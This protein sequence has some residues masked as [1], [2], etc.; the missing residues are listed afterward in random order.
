MDS[1][2]I[3]AK[4]R[5]KIEKTIAVLSDNL[6]TVRAGRANPALLNKVTVDYY[7]TPTP[8]KNIAN[9]STPDPRTLQIS[10]FDPKSIKDIEKAINEADLGISPSND[11]KAIRLSIQPLTEERRK[12]LTKV[13]K[14]LG[15]DAKVAARNERRDAIER[16]KKLEKDGEI[17]EDDLRDDEKQVQK[18]TE[19]AIKKID[20]AVAKKDA[21]ILEV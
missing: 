4:L 16:L 8:L 9:I 21:E 1:Q 10:P 20:E 7:G 17:T 18:K 19:D 15:E 13:V 5:E 12:E 2:D 11:G 6:S 3:Q 14:K